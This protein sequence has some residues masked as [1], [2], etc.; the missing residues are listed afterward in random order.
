MTF[1]GLWV[2]HTQVVNA[3]MGFQTLCASPRCQG[4]NVGMGWVCA[5][6]ENRRPRCVCNAD[7]EADQIPGNIQGCDLQ[8][9]L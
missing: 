3:H 4:S 9:M 8:K 6:K 1:V 7:K 2:G 5:Y